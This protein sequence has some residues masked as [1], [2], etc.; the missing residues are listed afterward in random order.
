MEKNKINHGFIKTREE[1]VKEINAR[2]HM[3]THEKTGARLMHIENDDP[4]KTF[5][6]SFR[7]PPSDDTGLPHILEHSV[8]CGS[9]NFPTKEPFVELAKGSLNTY[10][11][12]MTYSDKT[13][14]PISSQNDQD[15]INL[16]TVYL[17]GVFFPNIYDNPLILK[18]EG[19][20]Y[21]LD[22]PTDDIS[23]QGVV[24]NEMKGA[25]SSPEGI[26][27][28]KIEE[29][30]FPDTVYRFESGGDPVSIPELT[31]EQFLAFHKDY[32]HPSNSY[33]CLYGDG[34]INEHLR[35]IDQE[36]L[37]HFDK[38]QVESAIP[39]QEA[40]SSMREIT[41]QYPIG[42]G[43]KEQD[44]TYLALN[45]VIEDT[46]H[47]DIML[48][49]EVL[50]HLL[51]ET[52]GAPLKK[53]LIDAGIGQDVFGSYDTS[54]QQ[55][56]FSIVVKNA[57]QDQKEAFYRIV[58]DTLQTL[59]T[60][61]ISKKLVEGALN[62]KEFELREADFGGYSK[63]LLYAIQSM[64][65]WLYDQDPL[66]NLKYEDELKDI[67][68]SLKTSYLEDIIDKYLINNNHSSLIIMNPEVGLTKRV[69]E[70]LQNQ[71]RTFKESLSEEEIQK[72][73]DD[74]QAL[75]KIQSTPDTKEDLE[76]IPTLS[77]EDLEKEANYPQYQVHKQGGIPFIMTPEVTNEIAYINLYYDLRGIDEVLIPYVGILVGLLGKLDTNNYSYEDLNNEINIHT[78]GIQYHILAP[79]KVD[80]QD[81]Y[82]PQFVVRSKVLYDKLSDLSSLI[83]EIIR[84]TKFDQSSRIHEI[85]REMKSR[86]EMSINQDGHQVAFNRLLSYFSQKACF[87]ETIRGLQ[88]YQTVSHI[89]NNFDDMKD[90][91][92]GN[93]KKAYAILNNKNRITIG[94]T[95]EP[96]H[97]EAIQNTFLHMVSKME[98]SSYEKTNLVYN[99]DQLAKNEA[100]LIP[101]NVQYVAKGYDFNQLG[102]AYHGSMNVLKNIL[103][104]DYLWNQV[105]VQNGAYGCFAEFGRSGNMFFVSYRDPSVGKT[106]DTYNQAANYLENFTVSQRDMTKYIIGTIS[107]L[108]FPLTAARKGAQAQRF[109]MA[110]ITKEILQQERDQVLA[111]DQKMIRNLSTMVKASMEEGYVCVVGNQDKI[112]EEGHLFDHFIDVFQ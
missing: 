65:T 100:L 85:I 98:E 32:Y 21:K 47:K 88:F 33:I 104:M 25:F 19:W 58:M 37:S 111:T 43:E 60:Q 13:M 106:L 84:Q 5:S 103:A 105:R 92:I 15:F 30:L 66:I 48:A 36:Y 54:I 38:R 86:M 26:L 44:K 59:V 6:I 55:P 71:L 14:Y 101:S 49:M 57:S 9:R 63:G 27:F 76:K 10:L 12:A 80:H 107:K 97:H 56:V 87:N 70:V 40:F 68:Q 3:M 51:L 72:L 22:R 61:G 73:V 18:Q 79:N 91:V 93:L 50:E 89:E 82:V 8:L 20:N 34:D 35:L 42:E 11:N 41:C 74:T 102:L 64:K 16:M 39:I 62:S 75:Q 90:E 67:K 52:P 95:A 29:S 81:E 96:H 99:L 83:D 23:Y 46:S 110:G 31:Q 28:R 108:D 69:D 24:Y 78:G 2:V 1:F 109:Y 94:V 17:D 45:F 7:T 53:A 77:L 112:K 4:N